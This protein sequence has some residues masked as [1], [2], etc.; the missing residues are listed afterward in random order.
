MSRIGNKVIDVPAGVT[1][2][3]SD[4]VASVKGAK[5]ELVVRIPE[6]ISV[7]EEGTQIY[8]KRANDDQQNRENHGTTRALLHNAIVGVSQGFKKVLEIEGIGFKA[9][10]DGKNVRLDIGF[11]HPVF[12]APKEATTSIIVKSATEV[13][14]EGIDRQSVGQTAATIR[15]VRPPEPYL[16]KGIRYQGEYIL[17]REGKRAGKK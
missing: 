10:Q 1:V 14:V 16:G 11:S 4:N 13:W 5:G 7:V 8:V 15:G 3:V 9:T 6:N 12:I 17:R 2:S